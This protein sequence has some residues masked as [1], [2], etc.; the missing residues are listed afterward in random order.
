MYEA[1]VAY[2]SMEIGLR[3]D[4]P[5]YAG[6]LGVLAG[7]TV[8]SAA[9][10]RIPMVG[11]SLLSRQGYFHQRI[12][13]AGHQIEEPEQWAVDAHLSEMA[14]R[15][16]VEIEGRQVALRCWRYEVV[17]TGGFLVPVY[18]L[19]ADVE[20]NS[21]EDRRLTD[22]LYGG[23][24]R[25]RL[26]Q[27]V[28]LGIGGVRILRALGYKALRR[29]HMN[30]GHASLLILELVAEQAR[31]T[32]AEAIT[33]EHIEAVRP[34]CVFTTHTPVAA[35][36]DR[37][38]LDLVER[39]LGRSAAFWDHQPEFCHEGQLNLT[40]LALFGSHYVNGVA[41]RHR[42]ISQHMFSQYRVD[43]I[44]N[45][46][47]VATWASEP[48]RGLF[49]RHIPGWREDSASLRY[50]ISIP[51][52]EIQA[53]HRQAKAAL[54]ERVARDAGIELQPEVFTLGFA[55]RATAYKR[56]DLL[57]AD[58]E[59]LRHVVEAAGP[60]QLVFAGKA[61]P[62]DSGGK[63][64]IE[65]VFET[66]ARLGP[67]HIRIAYLSEYDMDLGRLMTAGSDLWLN[68]PL[69]PLE[70]SG[71]S[72]MKAAINGV[73][74][75]SVLDGWWLEGCIEGVTGWA[76]G[77]HHHALVPQENRR[78]DADSL[79][80]KLEYL[81]LPLFYQRPDAWQDVMRHAIALNGSFFNSER[82][83][84]QYVS[85]AYFV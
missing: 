6:G 53:T 78:E 38:P 17:G 71:T 4:I 66:A 1:T 65:K 51:K 58:L 20:G 7:D 76:I 55:R 27:E 29:Y 46:V 30:E 35:G 24:E 61:H 84:G 59:R 8:R 54:I 73:P 68:T 14:V 28:I 33:P 34:Q 43:S 32:G 74:S 52:P 83:L 60:L 85:K 57:F 42:E 77:N 50:A 41:K 12:D 13:P 64:M 75:F 72:G 18:L 40:Y 44:T 16:S 23:D 56:M 37:F 19:D 47:H 11:I 80:S 63:A 2:F 48:M 26:C 82:M 36:H 67:D 10:M 49:D 70:A 81:I 45:G 22:R 3:S 79:Y 25:Y 39:V 21:P 31:S 62:Q 15:A 69:P 5:T 9:D